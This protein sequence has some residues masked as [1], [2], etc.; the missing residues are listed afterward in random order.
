MATFFL[1]LIY[2]AFISLGLPDSLLGAAWPVMQKDLKAPMEMAGFLFM[3]IAAGTIVSSLAS[4]TV[5]KRFGTGKVT[6]VSCIMT[7]TALLG[8]AFAPS[9]LWL[10]I[11]A[12]PLGLGGGAVDAG[13]NHYVAA[14]YKAHHMSWLHCFWGVGAMLGPMIMAPYI[15]EETL[16][17]QG[18]FIVACVQFMLVVIL[19]L[20]LPL[21]ERAAAN[22]AQAPLIEAPL[23]E[24]EGVHTSHPLQIKGG[25]LALASFLLYCGVEA[26]IG[27]WGSSF[28][29][30]V[31]EVPAAVAAQWI[32]FYYAGI[33]VGRFITGFVAFTIKNQSLIRLGQWIALFGACLLILPLPPFFSLAGIIITG[34]GLAPIYP[35]MLHETPRRFG[36]ENAPS[37]I[38]YQMAF[39]YTGSTCLPPLF[40]FLA[41]Q[42]SIAIFPWAIVLSAAGMLYF[43][44]KLNALLKGKHALLEKNSRH[45]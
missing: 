26:M 32:S 13:L 17:R 10:W 2:L 24:T 9:L 33:T 36:R 29:V 12:I 23:I 21:W 28:V 5:L 38:G 40:G 39:A 3:S 1:V 6:L 41:S 20:T 11:L 19:F 42:T 16:W 30:H 25:R 43:T 22:R 4:G 45:L 44:E 14:H 7:A 35:C 37:M 34:L 31:K 15:S 27:L 8:M 18:Y